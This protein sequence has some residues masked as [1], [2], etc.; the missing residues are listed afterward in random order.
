MSNAVAAFYASQPP[1]PKQTKPY[2]ES[3]LSRPVFFK[4]F[5]LAV[6]KLN[7]DLSEEETDFIS[8]TDI[9][10]SAAL[11]NKHSELLGDISEVDIEE[12]P[13]HEALRDRIIDLERRILDSV[14]EEKVGQH[15]QF[16]GSVPGHVQR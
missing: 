13:F 12:P 9:L 11:L 2:F 15:L 3:I 10:N 7:A 8:I 16:V 5:T 6:G 4:R 14:V 1:P